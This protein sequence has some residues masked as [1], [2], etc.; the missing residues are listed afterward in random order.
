MKDRLG[1]KL[2]VGMLVVLSPSTSADLWLGKVKKLGKVKVTVNMV[3]SNFNPLKNW[4]TIKYPKDL[5][6]IE[7]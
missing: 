7:K 5:L 4:T 6:I 3:N 2:E 1:K